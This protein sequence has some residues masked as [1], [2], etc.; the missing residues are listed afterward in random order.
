MKNVIILGLSCLSLLM[1]G[2]DSSNRL[3]CTLE[4]DVSGNTVKQNIVATFSGD[5][6]LNLT[7]NVE[8]ILEEQYIEHID[9]FVDQ[10]DMQFE[11]YKGKKGITTNTAKKDNSVV[12][13]MDINVDEM[14]DDAKNTL[15]IVDTESSYE[16][17]K[18]SLENAGYTCK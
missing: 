15:G 10:I 2:C 7:M 1:T 12:F 17:A 6:V 9:T 14:D 11:N 13:N 5:N 4:Q 16:D 18:K 3:N 8:T